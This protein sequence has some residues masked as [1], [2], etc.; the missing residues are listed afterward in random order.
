MKELG[1]EEECHEGT[2]TNRNDSTSYSWLGQVFGNFP[3][4]IQSNI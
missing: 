4:D 1:E 2:A 3:I